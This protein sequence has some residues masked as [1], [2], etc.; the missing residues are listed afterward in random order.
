MSTDTQLYP[1]ATPLLGLSQP[2]EQWYALLTRSRHEKVVAERLRDRG[3]EAFLPLVH[4]VR[5]WSDRKKMVDLPLFSGY[6]F[7]KSLATNEEKVRVLSIDG[8]V[9]Y[10]GVRG[11]GTPVPEEQIDAVR[12]LLAQELQ[13]S[14][15]PFLKVGQSV[16]I[17]GGAL[18]GVEGILVSRDGGKALVVSV[19]AIERSLL[20]RIEGYN[21]ESI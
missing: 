10:V 8:V 17:R 18:D 14:L 4:E 7:V 16:R 9:Q 13:H 5:E 21:V 15:H 12:R 20:V 6:V 2:S 1:M 11:E 19:D 3:F